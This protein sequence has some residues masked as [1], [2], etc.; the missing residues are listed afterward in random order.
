M[1]WA[2]GSRR[3]AVLGVLLGGCAPGV[4]GPA[5]LPAPPIIVGGAPPSGPPVLV[6]AHGLGA[7]GAALALGSGFAEGTTIDG[8][9][10]A[11]GHSATTL[12]LSGTI[13]GTTASSLSMIALAA[14]SSASLEPLPT[15]WR[16]G[17]RRG[18]TRPPSADLHTH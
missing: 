4:P 5:R 3:A 18:V 17:Q 6:L 14:V 2:Q 1:I 16:Q 9:S 12:V 13:S 11:P 10:L 15:Y 7:A 8:P